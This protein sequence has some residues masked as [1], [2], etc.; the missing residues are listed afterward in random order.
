M[1]KSGKKEVG[2]KETGITLIALIVTIIVLLILAGIT[3][4]TL[5]GDN[6]F[7][8]S[9]I[10][11]KEQTEIGDEKEIL[12]IATVTAMGKNKYGEL[13]QKNLQNA[14]DNYIGNGVAKVTDLGDE[15]FLVIFPSGRAYEVD[16]DGNGTYLGRE[17]ELSTKVVIS[18]NKESNST[19]VLVQEVEVSVKTYMPVEDENITLI[20]AWSKSKDECPVE[21]EFVMVDLSGTK[22]NRTATI[23]SNV[24]DGGDYYLWVKAIINETK[25]PKSF[26][27][28]AI[29]E[30]TTL[31][32]C[33][34]E[35]S[36]TSSFLGNSNLKRNV[37]KSVTLSSSLQGHQAGVGNCWDVSESQKGSILA[38]YTE[39]IIDNVTYYD[40]TIAE[41]GGVVANVSS[42]N[43]FRNIGYGVTGAVTIDGLKNLDT[44]L[45]R[46][47]YAM[48]F[49]CS[50]VTSLDVSNFNTSNVTDM[51]FM[52][53]GC[54][55]LSSL[56]VSNFNTSNV[57]NMASMYY[58]CRKLTSLDLSNF[59]TGNVT[60]MEQ[61]FDTCS[62]LT[63]L[64]VS[65][66]NT[67]N[68]TSMYRMFCNCSSLDSLDVSTFNTR[69]VTSMLEMFNGCSS[70]ISLDV[71]NFNTSNVTDMGNMFYNCKSLTS[72]DVS[73]FITANVTSMLQMFYGCSS[74][75]SLD[76][77][78]FI[79]ANVTNMSGMFVSCS[80]LTSLDVSNFNT[81]NVTKMDFMFYNCKSLTSLDVSNFNTSNVT[82][83][84]AMF[85]SCSRLTNLDV[86]NFNT[87]KVTDMEMMFAECS[88][89]VSLDL[90]NLDISNVTHYAN[91][92][93]D[94]P[95]NTVIYVSSKEM[96]EWVLDRKSSFTNIQVVP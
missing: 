73:N 85:Q 36:S 64:D 30:Y 33:A 27:E 46:D 41:D 9:T 40:V 53:G 80:S 1:I 32:S 59:D 28:Y 22:L 91:I 15:T 45:T 21:K 92:F 38:W 47:M 26:G 3:V 50:K 17:D 52:F 86:S 8:K 4:A 44:S 7:I 34:S 81:S 39:S 83:M 12:N 90:R 56:D 11:A 42:R 65:N 62:S 68:V 5:S 79:T 71:S 6:G 75:A 72:L 78:N 25:T 67:Q 93:G 23:Y 87:S 66:F 89:L 76:V 60:N 2:N 94:V 37:I 58:N 63:S 77:N 82:N 19:P 54:S 48:F 70:L 24:T 35:T 18:A 88:K 55:E 96:K 74:L 61:I 29:K 10:N 57:T 13:T 69:N 14:L 84:L 16:H 95:S 49:G 51:S 20:Y 31:R 43:L